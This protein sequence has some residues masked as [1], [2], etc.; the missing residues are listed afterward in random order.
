[1]DYASLGGVALSSHIYDKCTAEIA[2]GHMCG[3]TL[4]VLASLTQS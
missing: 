2:F 1:M 4:V 3:L